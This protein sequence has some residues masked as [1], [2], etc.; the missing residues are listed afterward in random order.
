MD[1][2]ALDAAISSSAA[3]E[4]LQQSRSEAIRAVDA[5]EEASAAFCAAWK[6]RAASTDPLPLLAPL[7]PGG[8]FPALLSS[9]T[10]AV[11]ALHGCPGA[12]EGE[13]DALGARVGAQ[14]LA[15]AGGLTA[16]SRA[17]SCNVQVMGSK[18]RTGAAAA[19]AGARAAERPHKHAGVIFEAALV[20]EAPHALQRRAAKTLAA[21]VV[22][23]A[24]MDAFGEGRAGGEPQHAD[25]FLLTQLAPLFRREV[26]A[27]RTAMLTAPFTCTPL[28]VGTR[29]LSLARHRLWRKTM[30]PPGRHGVG[31]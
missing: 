2:D 3:A 31:R 4:L 19:A 13:A 14:L 22:L 17:P 27:R 15:C 6:N 28:W 25:E 12:A 5:L 30:L 10:A 20:A 1:F 18:R 21:K 9:A 24:R 16:L 11:D 26:P 8:P 29:L 23:A 7:A